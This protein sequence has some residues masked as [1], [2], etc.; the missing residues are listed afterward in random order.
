ME[1]H[2]RSAIKSLSALSLTIG[3]S[4]L[5][6]S[7][8]PVEAEAGIK[9]CGT[10]ADGRPGKTWVGATRVTCFKAKRVLN[11]WLAYGPGVRW[12]PDGEYYTLRRY[13]GWRCGTGAGEG[14]CVKGRKSVRYN[15]FGPYARVRAA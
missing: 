7:V 1:Y 8:H 14:I 12:N 2:S 15:A 6:L 9:R 4:L 10:L 11:Y 3:V 13:P 5:L